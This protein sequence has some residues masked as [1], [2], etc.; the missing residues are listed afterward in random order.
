M[1]EERFGRAETLPAQSEQP[2]QVVTPPVEAEFDCISTVNY[3]VLATLRLRNVDGP[4]RVCRFLGDVATRVTSVEVVGGD[5]MWLS[6]DGMT[7]QRLSGDDAIGFCLRDRAGNVAMLVPRGSPFEAAFRNPPLCVSLSTRLVGGMAAAYH[8][9]V[10]RLRQAANNLRLFYPQHDGLCRRWLANALAYGRLV[11]NPVDVRAGCAM[12]G[13][14][15]ASRMQ[16]LWARNARRAVGQSD[17]GLLGGAASKGDGPPRCFNCNGPH[18]AA[19]CPVYDHC[20]AVA[21]CPP[22]DVNDDDDVE[23]KYA[24]QHRGRA[25]QFLKTT[26]RMVALR[27]ELH[28]LSRKV[29]K[30]MRNPATENSQEAEL[31][32]VLLEKTSN[33]I[34]KLLDYNNAVADALQRPDAVEFRRDAHFATD[35]C[36][37]AELPDE[38]PQGPV[39]VSVAPTDSA[40]SSKTSAASS[41]AE[42]LK[43]NPSASPK[44]SPPPSPLLSK[45]ASTSETKSA[46]P[47][48]PPA[49]APAAAPPALPADDDLPRRRQPPPLPPRGDDGTLTDDDESDDDSSYDESPEDRTVDPAQSPLEPPHRRMDPDDPDDKK[50]E[51]LL[52]GPEKMSPQMPFKVDYVR[53]DNT[54]RFSIFWITLAGIFGLVLLWLGW[55]AWQIGSWSQCTMPFVCQHESLWFLCRALQATPADFVRV[56][57]IAAN[58]GKALD[59]REDWERAVLS[60][61]LFVSVLT[62]VA[63][64]YGIEPLAMEMARGAVVL[65]MDWET[66]VRAGRLLRDYVIGVGK[67]GAV[68]W[69]FSLMPVGVY[70]IDLLTGGHYGEYER[71]MAARWYA[72]WLPRAVSLLLSMGGAYATWWTISAWRTRRVVEI[73]R[74]ERVLDYTGLDTRDPTNATRKPLV[75][76]GLT[77][78]W[79]V[80]SWDYSRLVPVAETFD[81]F[82]SDPYLM[83]CLSN[84]VCTDARDAEEVWRRMVNR[85]AVDNL[86]NVPWATQ[87]QCNV[88][89]GSVYVAYHYTMMH[90]R[91]RPGVF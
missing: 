82:A 23:A 87:A 1:F 63:A 27:K 7:A 67:I 6:D 36:E 80:T 19:I 3:A 30:L 17:I 53:D 70:P 35:T 84:R 29:E 55:L 21:A 74:R 16:G 22:P 43:S 25:I 73:I 28:F 86:I 40:Q 4:W 81:V 18:K 12:A 72:V 9:C 26:D 41:S 32:T 5:P 34:D 10:A 91:H 44:T 60:P 38:P 31:T 48:A 75:A 8:I 42:Y 24:A 78:R 15:F 68:L 47:A 51:R 89:A 76:D 20:K 83:A 61:S 69:A 56:Y 64:W 71:C 77:Y 65:A 37:P 49:G 2:N 58:L 62:L 33:E 66:G 46:P 11:V 57:I 52:P 14:W 54:H 90:Q 79:Q 59:W 13:E 85:T 88:A 39:E 45:S 50:D